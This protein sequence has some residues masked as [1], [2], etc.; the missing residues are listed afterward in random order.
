[1]ESK[2]SKEVRATNRTV[3]LNGLLTRAIK[4]WYWFVLGGICAILG[5]MAYIKYTAPTYEVAG[6]IIIQ[7]ERER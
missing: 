6:K 1:M 2:I 4:R 7:E 3:E 5:S